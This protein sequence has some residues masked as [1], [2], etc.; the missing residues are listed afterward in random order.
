MPSLQHVYVPGAVLFPPGVLRGG[1]KTKVAEAFAY[2]C[3]VIGNAIT[4]EGLDLSNYT[5]LLEADADLIEIVK[6]PARF[7]DKMRQSAAEGQ[8]YIKAHLSRKQ[9]QE[10]WKKALG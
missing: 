10:N 6:A 1:L 4:F 2:G 3:A 7:L 9:F 5:L 8:E